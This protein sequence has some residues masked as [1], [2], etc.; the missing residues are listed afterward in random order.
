MAFSTECGTSLPGSAKCC[1]PCGIR[2]GLALFGSDASNVNGAAPGF[3]MQPEM[4]IAQARLKPGGVELVGS[5]DVAPAVRPQHLAVSALVVG[6]VSVFMGLLGQGWL[7]ILAAIQGHR[8]HRQ[9]AESG[10]VQVGRGLALTGL[11]LGY[12]AIVLTVAYIGNDLLL[13]R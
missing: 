13:E 2:G 6:V 5:A 3:V 1:T 10:A 11:I 9:I 8:A 4:M 12:L 7:G